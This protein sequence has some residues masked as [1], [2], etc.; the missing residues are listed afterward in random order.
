[1]DKRKDV[2]PK[3]LAR[4][5]LLPQ[6]SWRNR[7]GSFPLY[8]GREEKEARGRGEETDQMEYGDRER[9]RE[10]GMKDTGE[11]SETEIETEK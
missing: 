9:D 11:R 8:P 2:P 10:T 6:V 5:S 1:M 3:S 4:A 7:T